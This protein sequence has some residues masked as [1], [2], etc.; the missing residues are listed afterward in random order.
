M[1]NRTSRINGASPE[2]SAS[3]LL[4]GAQAS[5]V[6]SD[7]EVRALPEIVITL[8]ELCRDCG[9][10][11]VSLETLVERLDNTISQRPADPM[12]EV[13]PS[14]MPEDINGLLQLMVQQSRKRAQLVHRFQSL[15]C[16]A[17]SPADGAAALR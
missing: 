5:P 9:E 6:P 12:K 4:K 11:I 7:P 16:P 3:R 17:P 1:S 10:Q 14:A 13:A 8:Q 2:M 15:I